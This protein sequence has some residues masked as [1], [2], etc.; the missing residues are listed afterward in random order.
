M[1]SITN[2]L[3]FFYVGI[4]LETFIKIIFICTVLKKAGLRK[5][6]FND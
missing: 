1:S 6:G 4:S 3:L 5:V 2:L